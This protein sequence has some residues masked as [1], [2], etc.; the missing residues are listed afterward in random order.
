MWF[1]VIGCIVLAIAL[2][3]LFGPWA[4]AALVGLFFLRIGWELLEERQ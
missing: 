3:A 2:T 1:A 4:L